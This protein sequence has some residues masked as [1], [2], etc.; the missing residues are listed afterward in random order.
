MCT[1]FTQTINDMLSDPS[2]D[3]QALLEALSDY[4][5]EHNQSFF[6][7]EIDPPNKEAFESIKEWAIEYYTGG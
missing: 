7:L 3:R 5:Y 2:S 1:S 6:G 4:Y